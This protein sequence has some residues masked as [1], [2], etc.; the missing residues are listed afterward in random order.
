MLHTNLSR[1]IIV[2]SSKHIEIRSTISYTRSTDTEHENVSKDYLQELFGSFP[3]N[4]TAE[5][6]D[7][8]QGADPYGGEEYQIYEHHS[9][10]GDD[11][12]D[13]EEY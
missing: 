1:T 11:D 4:A 5:G 13:D 7:E 12:F 10:E 2:G 9:D 6:D 3:F 8:M